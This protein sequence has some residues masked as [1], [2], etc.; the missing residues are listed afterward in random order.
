[1]PDEN[2]K[3]ELEVVCGD[4]H[5]SF[6]TSKIGCALDVQQSKDPDGMRKLYSLSQNLRSFVGALVSLHFKVCCS[7]T[8]RVTSNCCG[9]GSQAKRHTDQACGIF[10]MVLLEHEWLQH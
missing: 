2:G 5:I 7:I 1:M 8:L 6:E 3:Q 10:V 9:C 4:T